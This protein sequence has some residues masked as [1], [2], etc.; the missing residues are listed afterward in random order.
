M[1]VLKLSQKF[2]DFLNRVLRLLVQELLGQFQQ[3]EDL[4]SHVST[5][6]RKSSFRN[7][8]RF[9]THRRKLSDF[10]VKLLTLFHEYP[11][12]SDHRDGIGQLVDTLVSHAR[13][14]SADSKKGVRLQLHDSWNNKPGA[15]V[16]R[17]IAASASFML[18]AS[19]RF[20]I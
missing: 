13:V 1:E 6:L 9:F 19:N 3:V 4:T 20:E 8:C 12:S 11:V 2:L 5:E 14:D 7:T 18:K 17:P 10:I 15:K 16:L